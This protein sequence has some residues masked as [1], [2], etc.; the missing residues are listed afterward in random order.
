MN[1]RLT[2]YNT[3]SM[4]IRLTEYNTISMKYESMLN[5]V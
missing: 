3:I 2:E 1:L 4:N 5:R